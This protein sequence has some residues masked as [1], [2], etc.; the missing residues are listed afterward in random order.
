[1]IRMLSILFAR[2]MMDKRNYAM[3]HTAV[4]I[5]SDYNIAKCADFLTHS[6][7]RQ[8]GCDVIFSS[9]VWQINT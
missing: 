8:S 1:M 4:F 2:Q 9:S 6:R 3:I 5:S 7:D